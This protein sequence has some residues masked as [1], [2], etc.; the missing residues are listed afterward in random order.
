MAVALAQKHTGS[1]QQMGSPRM[2]HL[3]QGKEKSMNDKSL[4]QSVLDELEWEPSVNSAHIGVTADNGVV[5]LSGHVGTYAEKLAAEKAAGRVIGVKAVA[6]E[7]EVRYPLDKP[8][9]DDI[10]KYAVSALNWD[11]QVPNNSVAVKVEKGW[12]TLSGT[13][14]WYFQSSTAELDVRNIRGVIGVTNEI[15]IRPRVQVSD[16]R[17]KIKAAFERNSQIDADAIKI[18]TDG[19]K[20]TLT[21]SVDSWYE[22]GL[23]EDM[24]WSAPGVTDVDDRLAVV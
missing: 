2:P 15:K 6:E 17:S 8:D 21:G 19:G 23:A 10:A 18:A 3:Y 11:I 12:V 22:R 20:V 4:Q 7:L 5:T 16:V 13:V 9:D 14:D 24:A 1:I